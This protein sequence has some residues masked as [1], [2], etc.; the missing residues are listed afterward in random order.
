MQD[1]VS[2]GQ[3]EQVLKAPR[4]ADEDGILQFHRLRRTVSVLVVLGFVLPI[5]AYFLFIHQ[6]GVNTIFADQWYNVYLIGHPVTFSALWAQHAE[7]REFFPNLI[8]LLL[9]HATHLNIVVE[10]YLSGIVLC[11]ALGL[12]VLADRRYSPSTPLI[13]YCPVAFLVLSLV[14]AASTLFG[15]QLAWYLGLLALAASLYFLDGPELTKPALTGAVIAAV[16]GSLS[17]FYGFFI[18]PVGL[19]VLYRRHSRRALVLAWIGSAAV[20]AVAF[21]HDYNWESNSYW[22]T[23]PITTIKFFLLAIGDVVGVQ[24]NDPRYGNAAVLLLGLMIFSIACWVIVTRCIRRD[25]RAGSSIGVALVCFGIVFAASLTVARVPVGLSYAGASQYTTFDLL[26]LVGC[27]LALLNPPASLLETRRFEGRA[28]PALRT[29]VVGVVVLQILLGTLNG[30]SN[31]EVIHASEIGFSDITANID[32]TPDS[33]VKTEVL[34]NPRWIRS[35]AQIA[36]ADDL[37]LFA[38]GD[39]ASYRKEGLFTYFKAVRAIL[40]I[41]ANGAQLSGTALLDAAAVTQDEATRV[42]FYL[43]KGGKPRQAIGTGTL[44]EGGWV[45]RWNT[46][47]V[48]NGTYELLSEAYDSNGGHSYS[49]AITIQVR[50]PPAPGK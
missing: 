43:A 37:S 6:Y 21:F 29:V 2:D 14:Q 12:V 15:F 20:T 13:Y 38:T 27:Y 11:I 42:V 49:R 10:E 48:A 47:S 17:V 33:L 25:G 31:A 23:H 26:I 22:F 9:A 24:L 7:H 40:L 8:V 41:P 16:V 32:R 5:I 35:T 3:S 28:W 4:S 1:G 46:T 50:N 19:V 18:W 45:F 36:Q 39:A 30:R 44:G 34:Q